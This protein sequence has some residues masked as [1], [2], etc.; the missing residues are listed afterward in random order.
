MGRPTFFNFWF[1]GNIVI[2]KRDGLGEWVR[3]PSRKMSPYV[4][5]A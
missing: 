3:W 4:T 5:S 1:C 2:A